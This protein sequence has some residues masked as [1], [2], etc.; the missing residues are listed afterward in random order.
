MTKK[1]KPIKLYRHFNGKRFR[2][3]N[4]YSTKSEVQRS[5]KRHREM[6]AKVR[7]SHTQSGWHLYGKALTG[8]QYKKIYG[9]KKVAP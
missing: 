8:K 7:T 6:G 2:H 9:H 3:I 4:T 5:A 1:T